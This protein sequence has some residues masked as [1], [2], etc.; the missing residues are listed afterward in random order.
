MCQPESKPPSVEI[1]AI[2]SRTVLVSAA[3]VVVTAAI[4]ALAPIAPPTTSAIRTAHFFVRRMRIY[5]PLRVDAAKSAAVQAS[6]QDAP[7]APLGGLS[8][9][10]AR[11]SARADCRWLAV[12][13]AHVPAPCLDAL[14]SGDR[15]DHDRSRGIGPPPSGDRVR[16]QAG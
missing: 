13:A 2:R 4:A 16:Q 3:T 14:V 8:G 15:R 1:W 10:L 12:V 11:A 7:L 9:R 6:L 5:A